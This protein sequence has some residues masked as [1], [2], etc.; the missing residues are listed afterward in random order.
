[1]A[2]DVVRTALEVVLLLAGSVWLGGLV[3]IAV[4]AR[5]AGRTLGPVERVAFFRALG[6]AYGVVGGGALVLAL[7]TA[8]VLAGTRPWNGLLTACAVV[9]AALVG[10]TAVGVRQAMRMTRL[11]ERALAGPPGSD[12]G[13]S[14]PDD[15][16]VRRGATRAAALRGLIAVLSLALAV[17]G[18]L[19][20]S[21][22]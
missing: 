4:V 9:A 10:T 19:A 7:V 14:R 11:R 12:G 13:H 6:R 18:V 5:V 1:V 21:G 20:T 22:R 17:L 3:T 15:G 8:A 16:A 2:P